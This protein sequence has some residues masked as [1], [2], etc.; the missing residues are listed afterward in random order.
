MYVYLCTLKFVY[1]CF[2]VF[3]VLRLQPSSSSLT[4]PTKVVVNGD[5]DSG[6]SSQSSQNQSPGPNSVAPVNHKRTIV[7][8]TSQPSPSTQPSSSA[9]QQYKGRSQSMRHPNSTRRQ[10]DIGYIPSQ[11]YGPE[12]FIMCVS[13]TYHPATPLPPPLP[14]PCPSSATPLPLPCHSPAPSLPLPCPFPV[15]LLLNQ[16]VCLM[17]IYVHT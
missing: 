6:I 1:V 5:L 9:Q 10:S 16:I 15:S 14:L 13:I 7:P 2:N 3:Y 17:I 4:S 8:S 12:L 11:R